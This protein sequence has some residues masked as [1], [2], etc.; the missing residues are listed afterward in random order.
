VVSEVFN[1]S[2]S[3]AYRWLNRF[4]SE[5]RVDAL[6]PQKRGVGWPEEAKAFVNDYTKEHPCF[7]LDEL[8][9]AIRSRFTSEEVESTSIST[10]CRL[11]NFDLKLTRKVLEKRAREALPFQREI[12][13]NALNQW[14]SYPEQLIFVDE[15]SKDGRDCLRRYARSKRGTPALVKLPFSRGKRISVVAAITTDGFLGFEHTDG[16]FTRLNF[17]ES[18]VKHVLP[19]VQP[20]PLPRSIVIMDN[21]KIH[22]YKC[23]GSTVPYFNVKYRV[24][25]I[26][27]WYWYW[28]H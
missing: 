11:L 20:W 24:V 7:Y 26:W 17:H 2:L 22:R 15:T 28:I 27:Y 6:K 12:Y 23:S 25:S 18:F 14:Y 21:A 8:Q 3:T 13:F 4:K 10:I 9:R 19:H 1:I 5:G 16:T